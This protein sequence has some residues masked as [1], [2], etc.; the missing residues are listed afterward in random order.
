M[1]AKY[2]QFKQLRHPPPKQKQKQKKNI[3]CILSHIF[4]W[5]VKQSMTI[6]G[7]AHLLVLT[8]Q[9]NSFEFAMKAQGCSLTIRM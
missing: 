6:F 8:L 7:L 1:W 5:S 4:P 3:P 9:A 2:V